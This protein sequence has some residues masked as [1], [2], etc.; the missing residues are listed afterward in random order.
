MICIHGAI[1]TA[2]AIITLL[3]YSVEL[4]RYLPEGFK[5]SARFL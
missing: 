2:I 5:L 1:A 4:L 3:L